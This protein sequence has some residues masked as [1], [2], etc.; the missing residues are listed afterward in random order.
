VLTL[1]S[2]PVEAV[3]VE[4]AEIHPVWEFGRPG[5]L[6]SS[7]LRP[8]RPVF[9]SRTG[10]TVRAPVMGRCADTFSRRVERALGRE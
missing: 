2:H 7:H 8:S 6:T 4:A 5:S 9:L 10:S 1:I 3:F